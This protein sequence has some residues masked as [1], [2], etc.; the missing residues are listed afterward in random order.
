MSTN[1]RL[2]ECDVSSLSAY[3]DY[4]LQVRAESENDH[5]DWATVRF[6]PM[7]DSKPF[8]NLP[9]KIVSA[10]NAPLQFGSIRKA[11]ACR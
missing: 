4:I 8:S 5:S 3:G 7:D 9:Q 11:I 10:I 1:L 2:T 6:K